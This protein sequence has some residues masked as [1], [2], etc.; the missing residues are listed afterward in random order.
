MSRLV[1]TEDA[2]YSIFKNANN[3]TN[4]TILTTPLC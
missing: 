2:H 4:L 1:L 3:I